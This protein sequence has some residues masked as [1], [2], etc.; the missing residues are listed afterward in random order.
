MLVTSV[1]FVFALRVWLALEMF[2][3]R[4]CVLLALSSVVGACG[5]LIG[6]QDLDV[7]TKAA[8]PKPDG[9]APTEAGGETPDAAPPTTDD[10]GTVVDSS[11]TPKKRVFLTSTSTTG[12]LAVHAGITGADT[13]C[14]AAANTAKLGGGPWVA[15]MSGNGKKAYERIT[16]DGPYFTVTGRQIVGSKVQLTSGHL[17]GPIDVMENKVTATSNQPWVWTGTLSNGEASATCNDWTS[18]QF[19][20]F[21]AAGSF[22]QSTDGKWTDNGGPGGGFRNWG[23]QTNGRLYCFEQ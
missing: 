21:G 12:T 14:T 2:V 19:A 18:E 7:N 22:D 15:W 8:V 13:L 9:Q 3:R 10:S 5:S 16:Y 23:C 20:V 1:T 17:D 6:I 11:T 4:A